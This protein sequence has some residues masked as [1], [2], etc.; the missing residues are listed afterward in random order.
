MNKMFAIGE[1]VKI[2]GKIGCYIVSQRYGN[3][4]YELKEV[5]SKGRPYPQWPIGGFTDNDLISADL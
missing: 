3:S 5:D 1:R 2:R 4:E